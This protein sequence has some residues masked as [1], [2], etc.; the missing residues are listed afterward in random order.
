MVTCIGDLHIW[1]LRNQTIIPDSLVG[2]HTYHDKGESV[3]PL[4][5]PYYEERQQYSESRNITWTPKNRRPEKLRESLKET[6]E[7]LAQFRC[8]QF[9]WLLSHHLQ[10]VLSNGCLITFTL[11][12]ESGDV[13]KI[14]IDKSLVGKLSSDVASDTLVTDLF[15]LTSYPDKPK[16]DFVYFMKRPAV[17]EINR[18]LEKLASWE[19]KVVQLEI[20]GP[21]GRRLQRKLSCNT[22]QDSVLIWWPTSSEDAWPWAPITS[23]KEKGN[24]VVL[25]VNGPRA[26]VLTYTRT[27]FDPIYATFSSLH[28]NQVLTLEKTLGSGGEVNVGACSYEINRS[29]IQRTAVTTIPLKSGV[30]CQGKNPSEEKLVLG[31]EDGT[32]VLYDSQRKVTQYTHTALQTPSVIAWHPGGTIFFVASERGEL[33]LFDMALSPLMFQLLTEDPCPRRVIQLGTFFR[34]PVT[35]THMQWCPFR[36]EVNSNSTDSLVLSFERGPV[37]VLQFSLGVLSQER[38]SAVELIKEYI[39]HKQ[40][41]EAVN[42]LCCLN[43]DT[44]GA[45]CY[46]SLSTI[47]NHILRMP[48]NADRESQLEASLGSFYAPKQAISELTILEYRD[49]ISRLARRFF[50]HLLRYAR[51]DKAFLL[52]VDIGARDLFM[53]LHYMALDKGETALAEVSRQKA[54]QIETGSL[55]TESLDGYDDEYDDELSSGEFTDEGPQHPDR[56][57]VSQRGVGSHM[58][59]GHPAGG[60]ACHPPHKPPGAAI[61]GSHSSRRHQV[62]HSTERTAR[63]SPDYFHHVEAQLADDLIQDYTAALFEDHPSASQGSQDAANQEGGDETPSSIKVVHFGLV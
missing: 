1:T 32:L 16:V 13:D 54:E 46:F 23:D 41:D 61:Q 26:E 36:T 33:Q 62:R 31:C 39:K 7:Y 24:M 8:V 3:S 37:S 56:R 51:F 30:V 53:D 18:K 6:E 47:M 22:H 12:G 48:L 59:P 5:H 35:L 20:P 42:L 34:S 55:G 44:D 25:S 2:C 52:A 49:P 27:E 21:T 9:R 43:W 28:S 60:Q 14:L 50:H 63:I 38:F 57:A 40:F 58:W 10:V 11:S 45:T 19:P 29:K 4:E 17:T 15:V